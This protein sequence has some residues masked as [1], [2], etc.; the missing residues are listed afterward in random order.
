[1]EK[2]LI[3]KMGYRKQVILNILLTFFKQIEIHDTPAN[4]FCSFKMIHLIMKGTIHLRRWQIFAIFDPY[5]P[6]GNR[7]HSRKMP[8]PPQN[9]DVGILLILVSLHY[10]D[11]PRVPRGV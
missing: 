9:K 6:V 4:P 1:M 8:P 11:T 2:Y 7:L 3:R 5:P 10:F